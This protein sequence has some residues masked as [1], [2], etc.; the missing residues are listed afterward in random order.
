MGTWVEDGKIKIH[1]SVNI[2]IAFDP[3]FGNHESMLLF[4]KYV[5]EVWNH[6]EKFL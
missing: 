4:I 3:R 5:K 2:N 6:P 1:N